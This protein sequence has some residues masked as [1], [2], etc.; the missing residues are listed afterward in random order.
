MPLTDMAKSMIVKTL[1]YIPAVQFDDD[2]IINRFGVPA[3]K[4]KLEGKQVGWHYLY[5]DR[6]LDIIYSEEGKEVLQYVLPK[7]F[8][9]LTAPLQSH[10]NP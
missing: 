4:I 5:P 9:A 7:D 10:Q 8:N 3:E 2:L 6:G 1:N